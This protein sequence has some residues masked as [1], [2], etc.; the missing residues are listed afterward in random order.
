M[1][2]KQKYITLFIVAYGL[3]VLGLS[4]FHKKSSVEMEP[5]TITSEDT[6]VVDFQSIYNPYAVSESLTVGFKLDFIQR[7][8]SFSMDEPNGISPT[9]QE[10]ERRSLAYKDLFNMIAYSKNHFAIEEGIGS[11]NLAAYL[12]YYSQ[13]GYQLSSDGVLNLDDIH[14]YGF[15][16]VHMVDD[17]LDYKDY[18]VCRIFEHKKDNYRAIVINR[19]DGSYDVLFD[20]DKNDVVNYMYHDDGQGMQALGFYSSARIEEEIYSNLVDMVKTDKKR[21]D[22][23]SKIQKMILLKQ[24]DR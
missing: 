22:I 4:Q 14:Y 10:W 6:K 15:F 17:K 9:N 16:N 20:T 19:P 5:F 1:K 18:S 21:V 11:D 24:V 2:A 7:P 8:L 12:T 23:D 3:S 13:M